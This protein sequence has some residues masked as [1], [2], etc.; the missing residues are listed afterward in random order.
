[1]KVQLLMSRSGPDGTQ[2]RGDIIEVDDAEARRMI[3]AGQ[4]IPLR[5]QRSEKTAKTSAAEKTIK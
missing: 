5:T 1:M 3:A 4:C 2:D